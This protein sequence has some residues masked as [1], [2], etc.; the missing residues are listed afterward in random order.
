MRESEE[1]DQIS[2]HGP[3]HAGKLPFETALPSYEPFCGV[4]DSAKLS[5][6]IAAASKIPC[7]I[8]SYNRNMSLGNAKSQ[9]N[10]M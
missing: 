8:I 9:K 4:E 5:G 10:G 1:A 2:L 6:E 7:H 3:V